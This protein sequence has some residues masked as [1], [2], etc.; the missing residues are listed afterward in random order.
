MK[1]NKMTKIIDLD[2]YRKEKELKEIEGYDDFELA[3]YNYYKEQAEGKI[4][5]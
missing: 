3:Y 5:I 2:T 1:V 4:Q